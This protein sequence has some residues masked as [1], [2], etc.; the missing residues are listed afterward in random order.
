MTRC[1]AIET[2]RS[3]VTVNAVCPGFTE[4]DMV[5][6]TVKKIMEKTGR[7]EQE[8]HAELAKNNPQ[9]RLIQPRE[10]AEAVE[11]LCRPGS[12]SITGQA[13]TIAGGEVM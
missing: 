6:R 9:G 1:V 12:G 2:A 3:G 7:S 13:I 4:T 8:A 10:V 11:W 5:V